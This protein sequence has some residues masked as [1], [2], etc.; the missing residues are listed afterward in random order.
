MSTYD[1]WK[2]H[3]ERVDVPGYPPIHVRGLN[4]LDLDYVIQTFDGTISEAEANR[5][6]VALAACDEHGTPLFERGDTAAVGE[7]SL[8]VVQAVGEAASRLNGLGDDPG[9]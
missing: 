1:Q 9:N 5:L 6:I 8:A 4:G 7:M 3:V 2:P